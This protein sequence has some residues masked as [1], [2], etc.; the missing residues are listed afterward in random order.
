MT[1]NNA[2]LRAL[3]IKDLVETQRWRNDPAIAA[4]SLGRPFPISAANERAWFD[5]LGVGATPSR[6]DWAVDAG[7]GIVGVVQL[8]DIDWVNQTSWFGLFIG[9]EHQ[10]KG[11]GLTATILATQHA[12]RRFNL[13]QVRLQVRSD[14]PAAL[15]IYRK[16][17]FVHEGTKVGAVLDNGSPIDMLLMMLPRSPTTSK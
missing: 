16:L 9:P 2:T 3:A 8:L 13:R 11:Y 10:G 5:G 15:T 6:A 14:N 4:L 1:A 17:G 12:F 7:D